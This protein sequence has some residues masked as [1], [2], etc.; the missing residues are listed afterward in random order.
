MKQIFSDLFGW[1]TL[2]EDVV[3]PVRTFSH[4]GLPRLAA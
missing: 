3:D 4:Y 2:D 1:T